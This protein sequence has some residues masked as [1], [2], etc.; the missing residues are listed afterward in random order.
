VVGRVYQKLKIFVITDPELLNALSYKAN[1]NWTLPKP[2]LRLVD[3]PKEPL[4]LDNATPIL[5]DGESLL[6]TYLTEAD[7]VFNQAVADT[8]LGFGL[9]NLHC[10]YVEKIDC[11]GASKYVEMT[12]PDGGFPY[13]RNQTGFQTYS[14]TGWSANRVKMIAKKIN[15]SDF[16]NINSV[17]E[18]DWKSFGGDYG[19]SLSVSGNGALF[20]NNFSTVPIDPAVLQARKFIVSNEDYTSATTYS[21]HD[22]YTDNNTSGTFPLNIGD[23]YFF[24]GNVQVGIAQNTYKTIMTIPMT[25]PDYNESANDT[26]KANRDDEAFVSEVGILNRNNELVAVGKLTNPVR[27][28]DFRTLV[29][30]LEMDF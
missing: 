9:Q 30:Q 20:G 19:F 12:F 21:L 18:S 29:F 11:I 3:V 1:R 2:K 6:V 14:G 28:T 27:K 16:T 8:S 15:T 7:F 4:T 5:N 25:F 24:F 22:F 26:F 10:G 17:G 13:M 23:Q